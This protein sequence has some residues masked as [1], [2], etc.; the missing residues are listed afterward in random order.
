[1]E[2]SLQAFMDDA[3][4]NTRLAIALDVEMIRLVKEVDAIFSSLG[5][6]PASSDHA[7]LP[8]FAQRCWCAYRAAARVVFGGQVTETYAL[9]R[10]A[11][12]NAF[13][14]FH[15]SAEE[16]QFSWAKR[17]MTAEDTRRVRSDFS[18]GKMLGSLRE[19]NVRLAN[20]GSKLYDL[21]I[22]FGAHPNILGHVIGLQLS[23]FGVSSDM[24]SPGTP[25]WCVAVQRLVR[26][27]AVCLLVL[28]AVPESRF[29]DANRSR[30]EALDVLTSSWK[31]FREPSEAA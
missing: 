25:A 11:L 13:Y 21:T 17:G 24:L 23:E 7:L 19:T 30:I 20:V 29:S 16:N 28:C 2:S 26:I 14:A 27:G 31:E 9:L 8:V 22:D 15:T 5:D 4:H 10:L 18:V 3:E 6:T 1:M 12:E